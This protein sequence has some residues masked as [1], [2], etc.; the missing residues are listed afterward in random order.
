MSDFIN[1]F[2]GIKSE[3]KSSKKRPSRGV[4]NKSR[5]MSVETNKGPPNSVYYNGYYFID[6]KKSKTEGKR[7]DAIFLN[8]KTNKEKA[9]SFGK[10][11][12]KDFIALQDTKM[13][14]F[15]DFKH[16]KKEDWKNLM[17]R[18]ALNKYILWNKNSLEASI[19]DY[20]RRLKN[21]VKK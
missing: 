4:S 14:E 17:S 8:A 15:Y 6:I 16:Q 13:K 5:K 1:S 21:N 2:F 10:K 20:K 18:A 12:E 11:G 7:Y 19:K 9:I 3:K